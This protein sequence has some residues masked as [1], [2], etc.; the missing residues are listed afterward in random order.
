MGNKECARRGVISLVVL[1]GEM[2]ERFCVTVCGG[3]DV[4][5]W[6]KAFI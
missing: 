4:Y 3:L 1:M 6:K 5:N 2:R